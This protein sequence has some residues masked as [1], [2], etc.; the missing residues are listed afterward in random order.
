MMPP[1]TIVLIL[2]TVFFSVLG[3]LLLKAGTQ[4]LTGLGPAA[5]L[6]AAMTNVRI[7]TGIL[8]WGA[9]AVCW[10]YVLRVAPL[11]RT[12]GLTSLTYVLVPL[13]GVLVFG[14]QYRRLHGVGTALILVG[15]ACLL[16]AD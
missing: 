8:A 16:Y 13:A 2:G 3:Q 14:E 4:Q 6:L 9:S 12:Y 11:S 7:L 1:T 10:L 5:F 15:V